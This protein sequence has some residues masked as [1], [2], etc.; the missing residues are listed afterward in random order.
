M[1]PISK[2]EFLLSATAALSLATFERLF[3][4]TSAI[5][6]AALA[7]DQDFWESIRSKYTVTP[8]FIQLENGYYSLAAD[9]VLDSY[10][11]HVRQVNATSSFYMR[12]RQADDKLAVRRELSRLLGCADA[13][14]IITRNTTESLDT[15]IAGFDWKPGDEAVMAEQDYGSMLDMFKLQAR[16]HGMANRVLSVPMHP[17]SDDEIVDLYASAL[18]PKTRLL[19]VCHMIN[20]TGQILPVRKIA[21]MAHRRGVQVM[22]DGA[23]TFGQLDFQIGDLDCDY[24][25]SSLH[26]WLGA[27]LGAGILYVRRDRIRP[28]WQIYGDATWPDDDIRKLNHTG[29]HPAATDLAIVDAIRFHEAIGI[30]RKSARLHYL[31]RYWTDKLRGTRRVVLNTPAQPERSCAIANVGIEGMPPA[32][33]AKTLL[34]TYRIFTVAIDGAG[35]HGVRVTPQVFTTL[36]ELDALVDAVKEIAA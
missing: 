30:Q 13:E 14:L 15:V 35:V 22:V 34:D 20:I 18:M 1:R 5:A 3:A 26:K 7:Q 24:Y 33:L 6:P 36:R 28:L 17:K 31:Q 19:M 32:E 23:H 11:S 10:I 4:G 29:T 27:P 2:R 8:D 16:R 9:P 21:D 25:G 12:T